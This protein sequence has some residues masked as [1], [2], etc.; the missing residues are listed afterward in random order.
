[1][2]ESSNK[3]HTFWLARTVASCVYSLPDQP[4]RLLHRWIMG[5][6][7]RA[8]LYDGGR[9]TSSS[10][11]TGI[12]LFFPHSQECLSFSS[13]LQKIPHHI[14]FLLF[15]K[16]MNFRRF[17]DHFRILNF[18]QNKFLK[19]QESLAKSEEGGF[20]QVIFILWYL[21]NTKYN[22]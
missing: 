3:A 4:V 20:L 8:K 10:H 19:S 21:W 13:T 14:F 17:R 11:V 12:V 2:S 16:Q 15:Y 1:M 9:I 7:H 22:W 6:V 5:Q 18:G